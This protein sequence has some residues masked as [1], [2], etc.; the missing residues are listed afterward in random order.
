MNNMY[1]YT[2]EQGNKK[3]DLPPYLDLSHSLTLSIPPPSP[4]L[5]LS[6]SFPL[7]PSLQLS[8]TLH[9]SSL[10]LPS[11]PPSLSLS[12]LS[13]SLSFPSPA[14][15][16]PYRESSPLEALVLVLPQN[17]TLVAVDY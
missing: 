10:S 12:P 17:T 6:S 7:F 1:K 13:P 16:L 9:P 8:H 2:H 3:R 4:S 5:S 15:S 14:L 11:L